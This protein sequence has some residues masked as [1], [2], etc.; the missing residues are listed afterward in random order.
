MDIREGDTVYIKPYLLDHE[1]AGPL[2]VVDVSGDSAIVET[3]DKRRHSL[4]VSALTKQKPGDRTRDG[5]FGVGDKVSFYKSEIRD[6]VLL[7]KAA[8]TSDQWVVEYFD[9]GD[10]PDATRVYIEEYQIIRPQAVPERCRV[11]EEW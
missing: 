5:V 1:F 7:G 4:G 3:T 8:N 6:G 10:D 11:G 2:L 9:S